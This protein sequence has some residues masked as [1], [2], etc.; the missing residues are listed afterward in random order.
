MLL[1]CS[2]VKPVVRVNLDN[3]VQDLE[4]MAKIDERDRTVVS[5][6][7]N[8]SVQIL[9]AKARIMNNGNLTLD[10]INTPDKVNDI[11]W[12]NAFKDIE[13]TWKNLEDDHIRSKSKE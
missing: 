13:F 12:E 5:F 6:M 3:V 2:N 10:I 7:S 8:K 1:S 11:N 4:F 9:K